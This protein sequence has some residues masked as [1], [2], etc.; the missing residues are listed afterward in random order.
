MFDPTI[1]DNVKV[2]LEGAVYDL[3]LDGVILV[4]QRSDLINL[5]SMSRTFAIEFTKK[6]KL[7][8]K[9]EIS[10]HAHLSDLAAEILENTSAAPGCILTVKLFTSVKQPERECPIIGTELSSI[11]GHRPQ[12]SQLLSYEYGSNEVMYNNQI[13]LNFGRKI[14]ESH[15]DD[16]GNLIDCAI[17]SLEWLDGRGR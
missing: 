12:L 3:D 4:T 1:F 11:W 6:T 14:D 2:V 17:Q 7:P 10:L 15:I 13:T 9:A 5:S 16:F 8:S